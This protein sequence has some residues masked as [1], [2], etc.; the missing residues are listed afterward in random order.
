MGILS[1]LS[2]VSEKDKEKENNNRNREEEI[3]NPC[4]LLSWSL[5]RQAT[6]VSPFGH[7]LSARVRHREMGGEGERYL[8]IR[9]RET[10]KAR[11]IETL[12]V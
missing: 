6:C 3:L 8:E 1:V 4:S 2:V 12:I 10:D 5:G 9:G 7:L 11:E